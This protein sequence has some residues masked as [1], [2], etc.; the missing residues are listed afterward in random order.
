MLF[1]NENG[2][3][4]KVLSDELAKN[5]FS[6]IRFDFMGSG[7]SDGY[8]KDMTFRTELKDAINI[9]EYAMEIKKEPRQHVP[10]FHIEILICHLRLHR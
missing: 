9:I 6:S 10:R 4:F 3:L 8:F 1:Y 7:M 5:G 2:Y